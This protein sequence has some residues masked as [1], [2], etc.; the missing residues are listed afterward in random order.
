MKTMN[1]MTIVV[2]R[3]SQIT[4]H[5]SDGRAL[6]SARVAL[7]EPSFC[8]P[9]TGHDKGGVESRGKAIRW[10]HLVPIPSGGNL[11][12][13]SETLLARLDARQ[14]ER[15]SAA[16]YRTLLRAKSGRGRDPSRSHHQDV[17]SDE[18]EPT[19]PAHEV[20]E[21]RPAAA[22]EF[23]DHGIEDRIVGVQFER[24]QRREIGGSC[25]TGSRYA[26][27]ALCRRR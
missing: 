14:S 17:E 25:E 15:R 13:V 27:R 22:V 23:G 1:F 5:V 4:A 12:E 16:R 26:M 6:R 3:R 7:F 10:Q 2:V 11:H 9:A 20:E 8:R 19:A 18:R 21:D 24:E